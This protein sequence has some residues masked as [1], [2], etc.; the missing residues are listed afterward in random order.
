MA[1]DSLR[2]MRS[3]DLRPGDQ[4]PQLRRFRSRGRDPTTAPKDSA[5]Y[6]PYAEF[7]RTLRT[8]FVAYGVG[9]PALLLTNKELW[10]AVQGS[11]DARRIAEY[12]L[13][14][15]VVQIIEALLYK[16]PM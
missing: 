5:L 4:L 6:E 14:G 1:L 7:A 8:W 12:F 9:A 11:G 2:P 13:A 3:S 10:R 15:A 16:H